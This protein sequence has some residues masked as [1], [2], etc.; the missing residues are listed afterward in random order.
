MSR[1]KALLAEV[2]KD[3]VR[4]AIA[5]LQ[6]EAS[7]SGVKLTNPTNPSEPIYAGIPLDINNMKLI[8]PYPF[9]AALK[10]MQDNRDSPHKFVM[11]LGH[12]NEVS[13]GRASSSREIFHI[14]KGLNDRD[15]IIERAYDFVATKSSDDKFDRTQ[16][17]LR[18]N[19]VRQAYSIDTSK[20]LSDEWY[21][22]PLNDLCNVKVLT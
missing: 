7:A 10:F 21:I 20:I 13:T 11:F 18:P 9:F 2:M 5:E 6:E 15:V 19:C 4:Q 3:A 1:L 16:R 17:Y 12:P 14:E 22:S 8:G